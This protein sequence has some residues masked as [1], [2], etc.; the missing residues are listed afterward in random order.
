M[1]IGPVER[2]RTAVLFAMVAANELEESRKRG[3]KIDSTF[4][5][6]AIAT[7]L[8]YDL[9]GRRVTELMRCRDQW[10]TVLSTK[11]RPAFPRWKPSVAAIAISKGDGVFLATVGES[12]AMAICNRH[13]EVLTEI[14]NGVDIYSMP[15]DPRSLTT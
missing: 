11:G 6:Y 9:F 15:R 5:S 14:T 4:E 10:R 7:R 8:T 12:H 1:K 2:W 3:D 13:G